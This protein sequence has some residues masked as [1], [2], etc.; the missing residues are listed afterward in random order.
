MKK[1]THL[2]A[3]TG[4]KGIGILFIVLY[5]TL[6]QQAFGLESIT[7]LIKAYGG[8]FG[9]YLFF[10]LSGF[11][12]A[13]NYQERI[14]SHAVV[15]P[16][17]LHSRLIRLYPLYLITN[18]VMLGIH[19]MDSQRSFLNLEQIVLNLTMQGTGGFST[20]I[21][22]NY[23][24][25]FVCALL[26]CYLLYYLLTYTSRSRTQHLIVLVAGMLAGCWLE[27]SDLLFPYLY[28]VNGEAYFNFFAG[29]LLCELIMH[30]PHAHRTRRIIAALLVRAI[31]AALNLLMDLYVVAGDGS[32]VF[33]VLVCPSL[34]YLALE[35]WPVRWL[36]SLKPV[37]LLGK[38]SASIFF[39]HVIVENRFNFAWFSRFSQNYHIYYAL[40]LLLL[41]ALSTLSYFLFEKKLTAFLK[42]R[43]SV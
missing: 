25:W 4:L 34:I 41:L 40:Y 8:Y 38:I 32:F 36:V 16:D 14:H 37:E 7:G 30:K 26:V 20:A 10:M 39:W 22:Y 28:R 35:C 11:L 27:K 5:H 31:V 9:N 3:L 13:Y 12:L 33:T 17:F 2:T 19:L 1:Q 18:V 24:T 42:N 21:Q 29:C 23:P 43:H 6:D 15:F